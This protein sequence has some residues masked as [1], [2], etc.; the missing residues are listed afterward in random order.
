[1]KTDDL[2][3]ALAADT[4]T[5][6]PQPRALGYAVA[7][8]IVAAALAFFVLLDPRPD[9]A[10]AI[11]T[12]RFDL[13]FVLTL[14][15]AISAFLGL[16]RAMRP[17][18]GGRPYVFL[19][20][21]APAMLLVAVLAEFVAVPSALWATRWIG[22][23]WL[24]CLTFIPILSLGP[25]ALLIAVLRRGATTAPARTGALAGLLA[26]AIG[27]VFYA[28]HCP[29][30]SPFFVATWYTIAICAVTGMGYWAGGR[31]LRW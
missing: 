4:E 22:H 6:L 1:M 24:Y 31:L 13:K 16:R 15:L 7:G 8:A 23:N 12:L 29:D 25:L 2:I 9:F 3:A 19:L 5:G 26:G 27:A 20:A 18:M 11:H 30:D 14:T 28:A 10:A 21:V 17:E